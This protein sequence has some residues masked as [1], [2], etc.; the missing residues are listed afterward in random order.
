MLNQ[1]ICELQLGA[2]AV[3]FSNQSMSPPLSLLRKTGKSAPLQKVQGQQGRQRLFEKATTLT[4]NH[5]THSELLKET[6][7]QGLCKN[8]SKYRACSE[9]ALTLV[10]EHKQS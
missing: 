2:K 3:S 5:M 1:Q 8:T 7:M 9:I 6:R 10:G 4:L